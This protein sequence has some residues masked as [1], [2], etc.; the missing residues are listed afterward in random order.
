MNRVIRPLFI[1]AIIKKII[2]KI[3]IV[4]ILGFLW[5]T[6]GEIQTLVKL[7]DMF[8]IFGLILFWLAWSNYLEL[9]GFSLVEDINMKRIRSE[10]EVEVHRDNKVGELDY[11]D[12]EDNIIANIISNIIVGLCFVIPPIII[13]SNII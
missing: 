6:N 12:E 3:L 1:K 7:K 8:F 2:K 4:L 5:K 13:Y 11:I 9:D 10:L